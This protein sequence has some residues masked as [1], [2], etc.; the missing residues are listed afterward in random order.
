MT[1]VEAN[2]SMQL[3]AELQV[4][5]PTRQLAYQAKA[6]EDAAAAAAAAAMGVPPGPPGP[7]PGD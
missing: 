2:L 7:M 6:E 4:G 3:L 5:A 1:W